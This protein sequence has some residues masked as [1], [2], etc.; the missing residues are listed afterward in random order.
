MSQGCQPLTLHFV[1]NL[2]QKLSVINT[3]LY[4]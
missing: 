2:D 1:C 4:G 3:R